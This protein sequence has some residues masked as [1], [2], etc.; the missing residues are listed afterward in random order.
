MP[1]FVKE[2]LRKLPTGWDEVKFIDGFPGQFVVLAR[3]S[4][5]KW[6]IAGINGTKEEKSFA[7]NLHIFKGKKATCLFNSKGDT[8]IDQK[9]FAIKSGLNETIS[10]GSYDGFV[11]VIE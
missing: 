1:A 11:I 3:K 8:F 10:V 4:G 5:T 9:H 2:F 6:Y 7:L